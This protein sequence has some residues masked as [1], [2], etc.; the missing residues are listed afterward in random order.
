MLTLALLLSTPQ[1]HAVEV[2][3]IPPFLRGDITV[4][5][6]FDLESANLLEGDDQVARMAQ[7]QHRMRYA[8]VFGVA[9]G[10]AV[11]LELPSYLRDRVSYGDGRQMVYEPTEESGTFAGGELLDN[12]PVYEG[13]GLGGTW[14]GVRGTPWS[15]ELMSGRGVKST[16]LLEFG[17]RFIDESNFWV[18]DADGQR[19]AGPGGPATRW[20][21]AYSADKGVS[22][23][24]IQGAFEKNYWVEAD[25]LDD[26]GEV[27][28]KNA[29]ITPRSK[30]DVHTGIE[31]TPYEDE[32]RGSSFTIDF[33]FGWGHRTFGEVPSGIYLPSILP[34]SAGDVVVSS[35]TNT[36]KGGLGLYYRPF[37][38]MKIDLFT[39]VNYVMPY[40]ME[41]PYEVYTGWSTLNFVGG[42]QLEILIRSES[43]L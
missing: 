22:R 16:W 32:V 26:E 10:A 7:E 12:Q 27:A 23:P 33:R 3:H 15:Q 13:S 38:Y 9:P 8:A 31:V 1:A 35:E 30:V 5:Y 17:Y 39:D 43:G 24:Y 41:H 6:E 19:G 2:T 36:L 40:K 29:V 25:I 14:L 18:E 20:R 28:A 34:T 4:G 37:T 42:A 11:F 21:M